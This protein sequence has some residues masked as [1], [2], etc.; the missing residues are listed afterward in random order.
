MDVLH[1]QQQ[2]GIADTE[3]QVIKVFSTYFPQMDVD[4]KFSLTGVWRH[5]TMNVM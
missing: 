2:L 1:I 4:V 3:L 5:T